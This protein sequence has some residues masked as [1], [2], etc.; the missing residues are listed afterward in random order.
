MLPTRGIGVGRYGYVPTFGM[1][2]RPQVAETEGAGLLLPEG[3]RRR[4]IQ[5]RDDEDLLLIFNVFL[6]VGLWRQ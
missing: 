3:G 4:F 2:L 6:E 1:G 5:H